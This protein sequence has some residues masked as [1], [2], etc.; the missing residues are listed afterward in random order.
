MIDIEFV[1]SR[2]CK[3]MQC[4]RANLVVA[5]F[6]LVGRNRRSILMGSRFLPFVHFNFFL[7]LPRDL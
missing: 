7:I 3:R 1:T 6:E 4:H 2:D 5:V